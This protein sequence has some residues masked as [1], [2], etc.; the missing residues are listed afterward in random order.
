VPTTKYTQCNIRVKHKADKRD[1]AIIH[2]RITKTENG[3]YFR[4]H[5]DFVYSQAQRTLG[6]YSFYYL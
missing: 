3:V 4:C 6:A 2:D 1:S 5:V